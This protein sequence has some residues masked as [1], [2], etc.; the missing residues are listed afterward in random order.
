MSQKRRPSS[1]RW[2]AEHEADPYVHEARR[3][4]LRSRAAFKLKEIQERDRILKPGQI[5]VDLGAAPGGWSQVA[6]PLLGSRGQLF[7][8]DILPFEPIPGVDIIIG[9]F[10]ED[11]VLHQL[12]ARVGDQM[13]DL[14][15]SDMAPN[16]SGV[17]AADQAASMYLC[18]LA[19]EFAKAHLKPRGT[20]LVK[21]FQGDGF[22]AY[23]GSLREA[24]ENVA[25]RKPKAS[26]PRSREV[27][28][29]ARNFHAV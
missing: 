3:L 8:L 12:E 17:D 13:V 26:R 29:L 6:R 21:A 24:F 16:I 14:V 7:A 19:F 1:A 9:D 20:L 18:E 15:M 5:V 4:G 2:L 22:D 25:I 10:R 11:A 23:L 27:Y 28:L